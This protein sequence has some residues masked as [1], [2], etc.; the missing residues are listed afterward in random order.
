MKHLKTIDAL[1]VLAAGAA[2]YLI[3]ASGWAYLILLAYGMAQ[4]LV[5]VATGRRE[6]LVNVL[7]IYLASKGR[8]H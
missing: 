1:S 5:G 4:R 7:A 8:K 6:E 2:L 3:D